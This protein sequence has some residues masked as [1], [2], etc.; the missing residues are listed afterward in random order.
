MKKILVIE[1]EPEMRRN[2]TTILRMEKFHPLAAENGRIGVELA[3]K[4]KPDL[5][6][7]DVMMPELDGHGV[8][9]ALR[10]DAS[11]VTI[12]FIFLT[13]KGEKGDVRDGM[14]LGADDYLTKPVAK[15]DLINAV[16]SRLQRAGQQ[17]TPE[18]KP[19]FSSSKPLETVL[20]LTPRVA[21]T[22]LWIAQGKTN[23]DI[24]AILGIS[25][26]TVKKHVLEIFGALGV[27]TRTAASLRAL[28][29]LS[30]P[31]AKKS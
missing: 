31:A 11:T 16:R 14:N 28:E 19:D 20:D 4:E 25:E 12:P 2:L 15:A 3:K 23:G 10:D 1:D 17:A 29:V 26:A 24:A 7:C 18:F 9:Q 6:L 5:I 8:L 30:S 22:L 21:E 13:A 27:E